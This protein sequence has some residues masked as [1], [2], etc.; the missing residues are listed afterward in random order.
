MY[1]YVRR[2][3]YIVRAYT[4]HTRARAQFKFIDP[5]CVYVCVYVLYVNHFAIPE[6]RRTISLIVISCDHNR[7]YHRRDYQSAS[8]SGPNY[9][10]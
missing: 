1:L 5:P 7:R 6:V 10:I 8:K 2:C 3:V 9:V 4:P